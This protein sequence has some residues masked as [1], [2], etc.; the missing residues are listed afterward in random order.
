MLEWV[1]AGLQTDEINARAAEFKPPFSVSNQQVNYYRKSRAIDLEAIKSID[2]T[3]ALVT[4]YALK[5]VRV[6]KLATLAALLEKDL[7]GGFLWTENAKT[8]GAGVLAEVYEYEEFNKGEVDAYRGILD[9]IA[10][11]MGD[12]KE[13]PGDVNVNIFDLEDWKKKAKEAAG[14][15]EEALDE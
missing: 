8:I 9:D 7:L 14:Q 1:A 5:E 4:G 12:R 3:N 11:E 10:K 6:A 2:E 13:K 15:M